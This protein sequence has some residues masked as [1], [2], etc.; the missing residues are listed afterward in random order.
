[1]DFEERARRKR[2]QFIKVLI[3]ELGM[4]IA[5][6]LIVIVAVMAAMGFFVSKDGTI[7]QS[8][9]IQ[10]HSLPTG[11]TV[12]LDG[13]TVFSRTNLSKTLPAGSHEIKIY[14]EGYD[15]WQK[16]VEMYSGMLIRLY[17]PRLFLENRTA[18]TVFGLGSDVEFYTPSTDYTYILYA[19][20]DSARWQLLNIK[21]DEIQRTDLDLTKVLPGVSEEGLFLGKILDV[22]WNE[23]G[24]QVLTKVSYENN[25]EW[26]LVNLKDVTRSLNLTKTFGMSF[27]QVE[28]VDNNASQL[29]ALDDGQ[30]RKINTVDQSI[31]RVLL[32][33]V[34]S[35]ANNGANLIYVAT[36]EVANKKSVK[37]IGIYRDGDKGST[38]L[39]T[40][41]T[42]DVVRVALAKFYGEDYLV[43]TVNDKMSVY[44]GA[45]PAYNA[46]SNETDF[47]GL[48]DLVTELD[49]VA[50]PESLT[51][52]PDSDYLVAQKGQQYMVLDLEV[53]SL[54]EYEAPA[55]TWWLDDSIKMAVIDGKLEVWD[56]DYTNKR[57]L[58]APENN[59]TEFSAVTTQIKNSVSNC[60]A[61]IANNN[62][63]LYY[64]VQTSQGKLL[65][66]ERIRD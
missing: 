59:Q 6:I 48:K 41:E 13:V 26:I 61:V 12:E 1:M 30:L 31:S 4:A 19:S 39:K 62:K 11:A 27:E 52:S 53:G 8:G 32:D 18:E 24:D 23:T 42:D 34:Q 20:Q 22:R 45:V 51:V 49:L 65:Q 35:F 9:L 54:S 56:F 36:E 58:V 55:T 60:P 33:K 5:V 29:F 17:Y 37:Q 25:T 44:Y 10:I 38:I 46:N 66:R 16:R 21:G 15:T 57:V 28:M 47:S 14:R 50:V 63:W 2:R 3:A 64:V 40:V 7:E 43:W